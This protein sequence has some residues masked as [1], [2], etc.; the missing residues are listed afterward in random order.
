MEKTVKAP[1]LNPLG[2]EKIGKLILKF[3]IPAVASNLV[4]TIYNIEDQVVIGY[5]IGYD[6]IAATTVAFPLTTFAAAITMLIAVGTASNFNL[7]QGAGEKDKAERFAASG[8]TLSVIS[9][10]VISIIALLFL[11]PLLYAFGAN[12]EIIDMAYLY[13]FITI[14]GIPFQVFTMTACHLIRADGSPN[15]TMLCIM[16]G[17]VFN[18]VFDPLIMF[19]FGWGMWGVALTSAIGPMISAGLALIYFLRGMKTIDLKFEDFIPKWPVIKSISTLGISGFGNMISMTVVNIVLNNTLKYYGDQSRYGSTIALGAVGAISKIGTIFVAFVAGVGIGCQPIIGY[20]YGARKYDRVLKTIKTTLTV[21]TVLATLIFA[22]FQ[23]FPRS[24]ISIFGQGDELYFEFA[25]RYLRIF[26]FM[27][28]ANAIQPMAGGY[29]T[30]TGRAVVGMFMT[31]TR[32]I[33]FLLPLIIIL[34]RVLGGIDGVVYAGPISDAIAMLLAVFVMARE[35]R[36][37]KAMPAAPVDESLTAEYE[38]A[39]KHR[40]DFD[41]D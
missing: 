41:L 28:F 24:I 7:K 35:F 25:E 39:D 27:T 15:W 4:N 22:C 23:L 13:T 9:G 29:F 5:G 38:D 37:L 14:F 40:W 31:L 30:S 19:I 1:Q 36:R 12:D 20:N 26:M 3:S 34:P 16:A 18:I 32:Q 11:E 2:Y 10:I 6:G 33:I 21:G 17:A 8:L